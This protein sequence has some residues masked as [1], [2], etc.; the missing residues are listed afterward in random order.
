MTSPY[1]ARRATVSV[2]VWNLYAHGHEVGVATIYDYDGEGPMASVRYDPNDSEFIATFQASSLHK[3]LADV[4]AY[5]RA[6]DAEWE[7]LAL[8]AEE[9]HSEVIGPMEAAERLAETRPMDDDPV[10]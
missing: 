2:P 10:F 9:Y 8:A 7:A 6:V 3:L 4:G 1:I 5:L